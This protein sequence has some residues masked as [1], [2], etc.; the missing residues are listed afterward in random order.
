MQHVEQPSIIVGANGPEMDGRAVPEHDVGAV[1][2]DG[3]GH[4]HI[5]VREHVV[6]HESKALSAMRLQ[7]KREAGCRNPGGSEG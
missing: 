2:K 4:R 7:T 1:V 3:D 5:P 6:G